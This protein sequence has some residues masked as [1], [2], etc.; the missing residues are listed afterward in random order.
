M[1]RGKNLTE[2]EKAL[3][4]KEI[5]KD[6]TNKTIDERIIRRVVTVTRFLKNP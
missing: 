2:S 4:M 1:R 6:K 3:I 5:A